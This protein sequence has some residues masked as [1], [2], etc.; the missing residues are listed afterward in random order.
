MRTQTGHEKLLKLA[1]STGFHLACIKRESGASGE[2]RACLAE[3]DACSECQKRIFKAS[4][5]IHDLIQ[6]ALKFLTV[7]SDKETHEKVCFNAFRART[8]KAISLGVC[9]KA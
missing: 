7:S 8:K 6:C 2:T 3:N 1:C 5:K 9:D 4:F